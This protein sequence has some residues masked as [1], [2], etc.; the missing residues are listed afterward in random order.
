MRYTL[1]I[2]PFF[3]AV[4]NLKI[5]QILLKSKVSDSEITL[6][7]EFLRFLTAK[8]KGEMLKIWINLR[9]IC[10]KKH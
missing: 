5:C 2:S 6:D 1:G 9:V 3:F 4:K 8:K 7:L 10:V